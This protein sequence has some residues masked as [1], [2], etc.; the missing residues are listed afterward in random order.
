MLNQ[1]FF[2]RKM[3]STPSCR[4]AKTASA[5]ADI[6]F[7]NSIRLFRQSSVRAGKGKWVSGVGDWAGMLTGYRSYMGYISYIVTKA[8][9]EGRSL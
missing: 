7:I 6:L 9:G 5:G 1:I 8:G 4:N 3:E 2:G